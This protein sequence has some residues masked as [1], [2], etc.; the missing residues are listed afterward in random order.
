MKSYQTETVYVIYKILFC[1][2]EVHN[3]HMRLYLN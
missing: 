1:K 2:S 3:K